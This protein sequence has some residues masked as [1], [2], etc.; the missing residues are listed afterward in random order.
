[1]FVS[2]AGEGFLPLE[3]ETHTGEESIHGNHLRKGTHPQEA[4]IT[5][6]QAKAA[7]I[8]QPNIHSKDAGMTEQQLLAFTHTLKKRLNLFSFATTTNLQEYAR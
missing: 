8:S 3:E 7:P 6:I 1:L 2:S 5:K 4:P